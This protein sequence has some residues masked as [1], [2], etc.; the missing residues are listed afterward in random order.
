MLM[1]MI[2]RN[3]VANRKFNNSIK[4]IKKYRSLNTDN[5]Q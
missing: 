4:A 2:A 5:D 1:H 3:S